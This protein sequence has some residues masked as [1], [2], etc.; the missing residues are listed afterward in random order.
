MSFVLKTYSSSS[1]A[2]LLLS[3]LLAVSQVSSAPIES[4][5]RIRL[6]SDLLKTMFNKNDDQLLELFRNVSLQP[7][8][9]AEEG[10]NLNIKEVLVSLETDAEKFDFDISLDESTFFGVESKELKLVGKVTAQRTDVVADE[11]TLN[12]AVPIE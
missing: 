1:L 9:A 8:E 7:S 2:L 3:T 6:N 10:S 4:P 12:F 11:F 5:L